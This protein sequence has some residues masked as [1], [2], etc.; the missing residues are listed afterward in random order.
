MGI[1]SWTDLCRLIRGET[2]KL[3]SSN[4]YVQAGR[5]FGSGGGH[6]MAAHSAERHHLVLITMVLQ[7][8]GLVLAEAILSYIG[9]GVGTETGVGET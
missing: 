5:A 9:I 8:S 4:I 2:L 1:T 6:N 7:F 3:K